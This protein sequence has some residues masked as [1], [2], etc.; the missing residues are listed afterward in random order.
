MR[1]FEQ[2]PSHGHGPGQQHLLQQRDSR[3]TVRVY[4]KV[5]RALFEFESVWHQSWMQSVESAKAGLQ[6]TLI[7]RHPENNQLYVNFDKEVFQL[8]RETK[9]LNRMGIEISESAKM[10]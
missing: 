3:R 2:M 7:I 5:A 10:A 4:N 1:K 6:A 8:I 9:F